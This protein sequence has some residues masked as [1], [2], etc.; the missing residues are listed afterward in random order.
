MKDV[1]L[2]KDYAGLKKGDVISVTS[3]LATRLVADKKA[4]YKK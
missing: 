1:V 2:T 3:L 4:K